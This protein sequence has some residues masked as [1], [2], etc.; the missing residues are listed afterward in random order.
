MPQYRLFGD[1][2]DVAGMMTITGEG[3]VDLAKQ[4]L[5]YCQS[6]FKFIIGGVRPRSNSIDYF[7]FVLTVENLY[8]YITALKIHI[9]LETKILLDINGSFVTEH[10]GAIEIKVQFKI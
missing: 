10:R 5:S 1:T 9:S 7:F 6:Y 8:I 3:G 2:V 4:A